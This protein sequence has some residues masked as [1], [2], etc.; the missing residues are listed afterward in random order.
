MT[1]R[2]GCLRFIFAFLLIF[3]VLLILLRNLLTESLPVTDGELPLDILQ[4]PVE[5]YRDSLGVPHLFAEDDLDL[6]KAA[7]FVT[8]QDRLWQLDFNRRAASGRLSEIFG[9]QTLE[10]DKLLRTLGFRRIAEEI[11]PQLSPES[12]A[13][14]EAY[15]LGINAFIERYSTKLPIEFSLLAYEPDPWQPEDSVAFARLMAWNLSFSWQ[16]DLVLGQLV[17]KLGARKAR[18]V[19][20][21][22]PKDAPSIV[23]NG[24][25]S[26]SE[27]TSPFM[28]GAKELN[29]FLGIGGARLG[30]NAWV[31]SGEKTECGKPILANDP[32]LPL[33]VPSVWYQMHLSSPTHEVAGVALPGL[34]G[35]VIGHNENIAWGLTNGMV[36]D[37]DFYLEQ[38]GSDTSETYWD[39][40]KWQRFSV[41]EEEILVRDEAEPVVLKVRGTRNGTVVTDVH[42][43]AQETGMAVSMQ[44]TGQSGSDEMAAYLKIMQAA[45]WNGF[46]TALESFKVPAQNFVFAAS[47]GDIGYHLAGAVPLRH[48][49]NGMLPHEGWRQDGQWTGFVPFEKLPSLLNPAAGYIVAANNKIVGD[50]YPFY[51]S[52]LWE[53]PS[54]AS[55]IEQLLVPGEGH[56]VSEFRAMQADVQSQLARSIMP[57][58]VNSLAA[59]IDSTTGDE[60]ASL[61]SL[62]KDWDG[63]EAKE[64]IEPSLFHAFFVMLTRNTLQDEMG[65]LLYSNYIRTANV[66]FRVLPALL[67]K[68]GSTWFDD[69][70]SPGIE[71]MDDIILRSLQDA[72]DLL[73]KVA[74]PR[75]SDWRWGD[76]HQLTMKHPLGEHEAL[77]F[78]LNIGP[79]PRSGSTATIDNSEYRFPEPFQSVVGA[80]MRQIVDLCN[81]RRALSVIPTGASG[82]RLSEHYKDQTV[83]WLD[84]Q[85]HTLVLDRDEVVKLAVG[86]LLLLPK[87]NH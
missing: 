21:D 75:V 45:D 54:R 62:I 19:F 78:L 67:Q 44:W 58:I 30:S 46:L 43:V 5:V 7:G 29:D 31:V 59:Q 32:H 80:S 28:Q 76:V 61:F 11:W 20:P 9:E 3:C 22:F 10:Q 72:A 16:I 60:M 64:R 25:L 37:V 41:H 1:K 14:Y 15:A 85:Y 83:R 82:Q 42:P 13:V 23:A 73:R 84:H 24:P 17:E 65:A 77:A 57:T 39:G 53:P 56:S 87:N 51:I 35:I 12:R 66:P 36:D 6:F 50:D 2:W 86:H 48:R 81:P 49:A 74:G 34:P 38:T 27:L 71:T 55:R 69:V 26:F 63:V 68:P 18:E 40:K 33:M 8:A 79:F 70:S 52:N 4:R 47:D